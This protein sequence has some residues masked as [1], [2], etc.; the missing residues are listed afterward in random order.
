MA[1]DKKPTTERK[2]DK[3]EDELRERAAARGYRLVKD[4]NV[5][6]AQVGGGTRYG[7]LRTLDAVDEF[8]PGEAS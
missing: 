5:W 6:Y 2:A 1:A 3:R 7:P 8:L 4:G